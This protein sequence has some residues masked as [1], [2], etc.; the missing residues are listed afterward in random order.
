MSHKRWIT[1]QKL[2]YLQQN[3]YMALLLMF[4]FF[5]KGMNFGSTHDLENVFLVISNFKN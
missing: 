2:I 4:T 1:P 5:F 3:S